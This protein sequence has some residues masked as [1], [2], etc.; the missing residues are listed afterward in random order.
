MSN[1]Y[2]QFKQFTIWHDKCAMKVGTD[3][4]LLGAWTQ[5]VQSKLILDVGAGTG[6]ISLLLAQRNSEALI[7]AIEIDIAAAEQAKENISR[8]P[9]SKNVEII[10]CDFRDFHSEVKF[11][12]IVS[13]PPYFIDALKNPDEQRRLARHT[14]ELNYELL[15]RKSAHLLSPQGTISIIIPSEIE[16][17]VIDTAWNYKLFPQNKLRVFSK[18]GKPCRRVLLSFGFQE[19]EFEEENLC[20]E[21]ERHQY[22]SEYIALTCDFYLKM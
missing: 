20:I 3:S 17:T 15:F 9:W 18:L 5:I 1:S 10:C 22:T 21:K 8:S 19:K 11:D 6:L 12:C 4:V 2:F 16:K 14:G 13:N 7:T